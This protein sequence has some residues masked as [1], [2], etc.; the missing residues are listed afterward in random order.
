MMNQQIP[1]E[2]EIISK[3]GNS[4]LCIEVLTYSKK[5][6]TTK[7]IIM[8]ETQW[9]SF[10]SHISGMVYRSINMEAIP[11][12]EKEI[13]NEVSQDSIGMADDICKQLSNLHDDEKYLLSIH[14]ESAKLN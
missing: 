7:K 2:R 5:V 1:K 13:F 10:V 6:L 11:A 9:L 12:L 4:E 8:T 14:F 3:S